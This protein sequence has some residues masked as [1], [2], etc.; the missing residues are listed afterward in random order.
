MLVLTR[1]PGEKIHIGSGITI[2]V[3]AVRGGK[4]R[5]GI[6]APDDVSIF[7]AELSDILARIRTEPDAPAGHELQPTW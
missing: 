6:D 2:T 5:L 7:R 1:K 3:V 4:T